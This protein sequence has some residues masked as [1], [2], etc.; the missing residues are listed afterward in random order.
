ML[1][2]LAEAAM[3]VELVCQWGPADD[4]PG[5][6][7]GLRT[8]IVAVQ[9]AGLLT[10]NCVQ[11]RVGRERTR[12]ISTLAGEPRSRIGEMGRHAGVGC[13]G[14]G[15]R[16]RAYGEVPVV[17]GP[18]SGRRSMTDGPVGA[19]V[20][21]PLLSPR[22]SRRRLVCYCGSA[23]RV[24]SGRPGGLLSGVQGPRCASRASIWGDRDRRTTAAVPDH[25]LGGG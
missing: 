22:A 18:W 1:F 12:P 5:R 23:A 11:D 9:P 14:A 21:P 4:G 24:P 20:G 16:R 2:I 10:E 25:E 13:A 17:A 6:E 15:W 3:V 19:S 8:A 7:H